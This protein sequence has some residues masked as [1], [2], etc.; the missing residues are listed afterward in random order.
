MF[1][2]KYTSE[3]LVLYMFLVVFFLGHP[4]YLVL[5]QNK[6][7]N[8]KITVDK[9]FSYSHSTTGVG[10]TTTTQ[11]LSPWKYKIKWNSFL[12]LTWLIFHQIKHVRP[13]SDAEFKELYDDAI[14]IAI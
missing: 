12:S 7:L 8:E 5:S 2:L 3:H 6:A 11:Q 10:A 13:P 1:Y 9:S 4:V 14:T